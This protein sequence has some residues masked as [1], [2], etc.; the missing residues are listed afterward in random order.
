MFKA[1]RVQSER[2]P[3]SRTLSS[4][5]NNDDDDDEDDDEEEDIEVTSFSSGQRL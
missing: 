5:E 2:L 3:S 4:S 1:I